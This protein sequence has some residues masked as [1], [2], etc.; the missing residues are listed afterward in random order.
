MIRLIGWCPA[1]A[2]E[3]GNTFADSEE[4]GRRGPIY[5]VPM[6]MEGST[7]THY[8]FHAW[9]DADELALI[10]TPQVQELMRE[11][12]AETITGM[13]WEDFLFASGFHVINQEGA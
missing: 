10:A 3:A 9:V 11:Y 12:G 8:G 13:P 4:F 6:A 2:R 7:P 1:E 5:S